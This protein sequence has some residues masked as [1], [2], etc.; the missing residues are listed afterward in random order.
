[1]KAA[2]A[3]Y[4][5]GSGI[6]SF[7][8]R[9]VICPSESPST[10]RRSKDAGRRIMTLERSASANVITWTHSDLFVVLSNGGRCL[11]AD[12]SENRSVDRHGP[13]NEISRHGDRRWRHATDV[14]RR[15]A[16]AGR[17]AGH[18]WRTHLDVERRHR[19][20][21][22]RRHGHA[23]VVLD[24]RWQ[25]DC[26]ITEPVRRHT[27]LS[28]RVTWRPIMHVITASSRREQQ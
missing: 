5:T 1:M 24:K 19:V 25:A 22:G 9:F 18:D 7:P 17:R 11:Q 13:Q 16:V 8:F 6:A 4:N 23:K 12:G 15:V 26:V 14:R 20:G 3:G 10:Y 21:G 28:L 2:A 27:H